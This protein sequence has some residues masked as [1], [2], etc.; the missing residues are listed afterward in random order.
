MTTYRRYTYTTTLSAEYKEA[1][2]RTLETASARCWWF[3][4]PKVEDGDPLSFSFVVAARD[5][6][7]AH[8]RANQLAVNV[9]YASGSAEAA[10]VDVSWTRLPPHLNRGFLRSPH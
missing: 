10:I 3:T 9:A 2:S 5:Q 7:F 6:W 4:E 8:R 1:A